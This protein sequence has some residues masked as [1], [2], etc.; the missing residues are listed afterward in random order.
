MD[1]A[2]WDLPGQRTG[3]PLW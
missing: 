2:L 3:Q 1:I